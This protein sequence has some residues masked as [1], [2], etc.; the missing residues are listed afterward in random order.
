M[1]LK[2]QQA[3]AVRR[4]TRLEDVNAAMP[5]A[6]ARGS[7]FFADIEHNQLNSPALAVLRFL[8]SH[9]E[10]AALSRESLIRHFT[11]Q[12]D[13]SLRLLARRELIEETEQ[14]YSVK[15]ELIRRWFTHE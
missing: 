1:A 11:R 12:V 3:P 10:G 7:L 5:E 14:G 8:A 2:N 6:L 4:L 15:L 9:G 13:Y